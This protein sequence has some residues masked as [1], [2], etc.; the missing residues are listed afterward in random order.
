MTFTPRRA[1]GSLVLLALL[2]WG[3]LFLLLAWLA[4]AQDGGWLAGAPAPT[5]TSAERAAVTAR[6]TY[7]GSAAKVTAARPRSTVVAG[8]ITATRAPATDDGEASVQGTPRVLTATPP[9]P[10]AGPELPAAVDWPATPDLKDRRPLA[11]TAH[12]KVFAEREDSLLEQTAR[13]WSPRLEAIL[14]ADSRRLD[15]R[16]LADPVSVV[17][18]RRYTARCPAR[19]LAATRD[20]PPLLML[21]IDE[22]SGPVQIEAVLAH[23]MAHH[24]TLDDRFVGDA[25]LTEGIAN[26]GGGAAVLRWQGQQSWPDAV[27]QYWR[28][29]R[30]VSITDETALQPRLG[31]DCIA[32]RDRVYNIRTAFV[33]WLVGRIGIDRVLAM[34]AASVVWTDPA[35]GERRQRSLPDY[36]AAAGASLGELERRFLRTLGLGGPEAMV[37]QLRLELQGIDVQ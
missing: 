17:F 23:E 5:A 30:Y 32:R 29:G 36:E 34:P 26:W 27:R 28:Q 31:E 15:G 11:E 8:A 1:V 20:A 9:G 14:A 21:F 4:S 19:G 33:D 25:V 24:L 18:A 35:S 3:I 6:S 10:A 12:F 37:L 2:A 16:T 13:A 7:D 22:Q